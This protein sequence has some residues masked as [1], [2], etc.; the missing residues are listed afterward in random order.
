MHVGRSELLAGCTVT[1]SDGRVTLAGDIDELNADDIAERVCAGVANPSRVSDL[2]L[3][4]VTFFSAAGVRLLA[5][6]AAA[7][8]MADAI[9]HVTCSPTVWRIADLCGGTELPGLVLDQVGNQ[10]PDTA[11]GNGAVR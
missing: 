3:T 5:K 7:A 2:D 10:D 8:C 1:W 9:V 4:A 11:P 6:V